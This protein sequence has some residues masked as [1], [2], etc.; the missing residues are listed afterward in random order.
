MHSV[1]ASR[2]KDVHNTQGSLNKVEIEVNGV[3]TDHN[4]EKLV[5]FS[6]NIVEVPSR[7]TKVHPL[8]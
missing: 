6:D 3:K 1:S 2:S 7:A 4:G 5:L 8:D